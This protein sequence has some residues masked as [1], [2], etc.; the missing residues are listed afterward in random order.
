MT[1]QAAMTPAMMQA[2]ILERLTGETGDPAHLVETARSLCRRGCP[3]FAQALA[4]E[5]GAPVEVE[6]GDVEIARMGEAVSERGANDA[7]VLAA[8]AASPDALVMRL[9]PDAVSLAVGVLFGADPDMPVAAIE[10]DLSS[11]EIEVAAIVFDCLAKALDGSGER[12]LRIRFPLGAPVSGEEAAKVALR[13][14]PA[15]RMTFSLFTPAGSGRLTLTMPQ[16]LLLKPR[17]EGGV[18]N[19]ADRA[20]QPEWANRF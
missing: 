5:L 19:E 12:G 16:R 15:V 2:S 20:R 14:G 9:D 11:T 17:G 4:R 1:G 3:P 6:L 18:A 8:S 13:D 7:L 10:R